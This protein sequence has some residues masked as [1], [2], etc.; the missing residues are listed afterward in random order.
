[1][2]SAWRTSAPAPLASISGTTPMMKAKEVI[3]IGRRRRR[4]ACNTA[5]DRVMALLVLQMLG[6]LDDQDRVLAGE[7]DE[8]DEADLREHVVVAV[9]EEHAA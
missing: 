7:A 1:M 4:A 6:E 3:R 2:P 8:H 9:I 5:D